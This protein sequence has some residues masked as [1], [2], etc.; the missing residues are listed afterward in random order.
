MPSKRI[1]RPPERAVTL[2]LIVIGTGLRL[3]QYLANN[4]LFVDEAAL[5]RNIIDRPLSQLFQGLD[6]AQSAPVGFLLVQKGIITV[7][8]TSEYALRAFPL[9]C[10]I[11]ALLLFWRLAERV[12]SG[13]WVTYAVG[14]FALGLPFI[15]F[16]SL[17]K[18]YSSD[19]AIAVLILLAS[20][21]L[22]QR[23]VTRG[24]AWLL[25][26][27][28][29]AAVWFSQPALFVLAGIGAALLFEVWVARDDTAGRLLVSIWILWAGNALAAAAFA[30]SIVTAADRAFFRWI[31]A[32][33]FMPMP[34]R[35]VV[36]LTWVLGKLTWAFGTF[37]SGMGEMHGGLGY[38]WSFAFTLVMLIGL[39]SFWKTRRDISLF[40]VLP[41]VVTATASAFKLYPFT[42][43]LFAFLLPGLLLSTAA[44][45]NYLMTALAGRLNILG[46]AALAILVGAPVYAT[47]TNLPPFWLQHVRPVIEQVYAERRPGDGVY[48]FYG[49]GQAFRYYATHLRLSMEDVRIGRCYAADPREYLREL[50][51]FRDQSRLWVLV[52][53]ALP[54][55]IEVEAA[56]MLEYL[57]EIG[58]REKTIAVPGSR[59]YSVEAANGYL[60]DL[61]DRQ[62]LQSTTASTF[63]IAPGRRID[64]ARPWRCYG[65]SQ[66]DPKPR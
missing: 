19:T 49:A 57:D 20:I 65:V 8:G 52:T 62:R 25:G 1:L 50:D 18:Q 23:S 34:P 61:T 43:R 12:L 22:R 51:Q 55:A 4:S 36:D 15:V 31:W 10:G 3:W 14:L 41:I 27:V 11:L 5:A 64:P 56:L 39:W 42:A 54:Q 37:A 2:L 29:A 47:A 33:G 66:I 59:A 17:V 21:E 32:D 44:G 48:V 13:W 7:F 35:S 28:G 24:R 16:S 58:R 60:Y 9:G 46:N 45:A 6:Y 63:A 38:R 26:V 40:L 53:S 30:Q